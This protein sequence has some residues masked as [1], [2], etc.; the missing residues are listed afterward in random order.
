MKHGGLAIAMDN[1]ASS[2]QIMFSLMN[3][4]NLGDAA[5]ARDRKSRDHVYIGI[6][7]HHDLLSII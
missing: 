2:L 1:P 7:R 3:E 6:S 5:A 4:S